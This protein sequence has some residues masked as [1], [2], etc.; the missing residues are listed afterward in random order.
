MAAMLHR[1]RLFCQPRK[2]N[3]GGRKERRE[4]EKLRVLRALCGEF[5]IVRRLAFFGGEDLAEFSFAVRTA[6]GFQGADS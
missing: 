3:R 4:K 6:Y 1:P 2:F 5:L